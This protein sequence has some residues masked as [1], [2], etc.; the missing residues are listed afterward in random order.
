VQSDQR[1]KPCLRHLVL[2]PVLYFLGAK[3]GVALTVMPEGMAI[4]W[5][6]N[7]IVL[8]ALIHFRGRGYP[9]LAG[10]ILAAEV[11]ADLPT[12][13]IGEAL[14]FGINNLAEATIAY[15]LLT[16]W[17]FNPRFASLA[18]LVKF[19]VAGPLA[20]AFVAACFGGLIY[21]AFR[22]TQTSYLEFLRIWWFGDALGLMILTPL[23]L[24]WWTARL[25]GAPA[26]APAVVP[27]GLVG[28]GALTTLGFL[29]ASRDGTLLGIHVGPVLLLPFVIF[30]AARHSVAATALTVTAVALVVLILTTKGS[31]PFGHGTP[32]DAVIHAQEFVFIM[33][34]LALGLAALLSQIRASQDELELANTELKKRAVS[35][36]QGN[37]DLRRAEAEVVA[38]NEG[39]ERRV[40]ERTRELEDALVQVKRLQGLLPIC[41]WCKKVR[42][43]ENY[44]HSVEEYISQRTEAR[45][46]H[47]IC[48]DCFA[49]AMSEL[50]PPGDG[51]TDRAVESGAAPDCGGR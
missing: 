21:S 1:P 18:D 23:V 19:V 42:D 29:I 48:P 11:A 24:S 20:A 39:L 15:A 49:K 36:E 35:L 30:V 44:W 22:G 3:A 41:A 32:R 43:D 38:L 25:P 8:A 4:L 12:F 16:R 33:S 6:P 2:L 10:L 9:L 14:L 7:A 26:R 27:D 40:R 50:M 45:F 17:H 34:S 13:S 5:P 31:N 37:L 46:S 47:S 28:L 51:A